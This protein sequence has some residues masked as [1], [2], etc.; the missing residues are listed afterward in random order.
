MAIRTPL[1][2]PWVTMSTPPPRWPFHYYNSVANNYISQAQQYSQLGMDMGYDT[3]LSPPSSRPI[4]K[5]TAPPTPTTSLQSRPW[6]S[7]SASRHVCDAA[8]QEGYTLSEEGQQSVEDNMD[9]HH[10]YGVQAV[11]VLRILSPDDLRP[12]PSPSS[13]KC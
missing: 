10:T 5:R 9:A 12:G 2:P 7:C 8:E 4:M 13:R 11:P 1:L 3:S 6:I